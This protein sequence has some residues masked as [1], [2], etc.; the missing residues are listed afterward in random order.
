MPTYVVFNEIGARI[1]KNP[2]NE[3]D[4]DAN[5]KAVRDPDLQW[6]QGIPPHFWKF[7]EGRILPMNEQEKQARK[8][9]IDTG[10]FV[11]D[12]SLL[13]KS[14]K[15]D[16]AK[17]ILQ[18][19]F[20]EL[21]NKNGITP[22]RIQSEVER[23]AALSV[24]SSMENFKKE[25]SVAVRESVLALQADTFELEKKLASYMYWALVA[26]AVNIAGFAYLLLFKK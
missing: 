7:E 22:E 10:N 6:V 4:F 2:D 25:A 5:P 3:A 21:L 18:S 20:A 15:A 17:K 16:L 14:G 13:Q 23:H 9:Q 1:V 11:E 12:Y 26:Q 8:T 19:E 24:G